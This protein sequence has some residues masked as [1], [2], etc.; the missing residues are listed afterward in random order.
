MT[1]AFSCNSAFVM[2]ALEPLTGCSA[3]LRARPTGTT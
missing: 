2:A 3:G 1:I